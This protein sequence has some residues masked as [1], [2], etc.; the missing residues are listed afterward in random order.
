MNSIRPRRSHPGLPPGLG[1]VALLAVGQ[2]HAYL[3]GGNFGPGSG[4][5]QFRE[6]GELDLGFAHAH[7][8]GECGRGL[9]AVIRLLGGDGRITVA[10]LAVVAPQSEVGAKAASYEDQGYQRDEPRKQVGASPGRGLRGG[11]IRGGLICGG[12]VRARLVRRPVG[13]PDWAAPRAAPQA[14]PWVAPYLGRV[15]VSERRVA[16]GGVVDSRPGR[17]ARTA[18][19]APANRAAPRRRVPPAVPGTLLSWSSTNPNS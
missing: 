18:P 5:D 17:R 15:L 14:V 13:T 11:L 6:I 12:L 1:D 10:V 16:T 7:A 4:L 3:V 19:P 9:L 2:D 8:V